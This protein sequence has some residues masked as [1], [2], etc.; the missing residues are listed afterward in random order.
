MEKQAW[1]LKKEVSIGNV[2]TIIGVIFASMSAYFSLDKRVAVIE[3]SQV[4]QLIIDRD[5]DA[6]RLSFKHEINERF[7][8]IDDKLEWLVRNAVVNKK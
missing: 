7:N 4:K 8:R 3:E 6:D 1:V 5:R 2:L